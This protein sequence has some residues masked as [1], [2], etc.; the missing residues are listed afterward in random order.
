M[1]VQKVDAYWQSL[2]T[3]SLKISERICLMASWVKRGNGSEMALGEMPAPSRPRSAILWIFSGGW[4]SRC[5]A[6]S[7][8]RF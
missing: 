8:V 6:G 2:S 1:L 3:G 7:K 5:S 4:K